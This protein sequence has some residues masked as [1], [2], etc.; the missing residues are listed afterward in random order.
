MHIQIRVSAPGYE[1]LVTRHY[2]QPEAGQDTF[3]RVLI[4]AEAEKD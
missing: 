1:T 3:D 2:P 4:P